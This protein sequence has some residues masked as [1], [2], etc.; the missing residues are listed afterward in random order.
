MNSTTDIPDCI[1]WEISEAEFD[2]KLCKFILI[3]VDGFEGGQ[4][5]IESDDDAQA[6]LDD[7]C[8]VF[9]LGYMKGTE[10]KNNSS[11]RVN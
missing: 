8:R 2:G 5:E 4:W 1:S 10:Y 9:M 7:F 11:N 3:D 6:V